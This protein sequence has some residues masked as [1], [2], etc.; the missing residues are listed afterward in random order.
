MSRKLKFTEVM[1]AS[2]ILRQMDIKSYINTIV[3][4][5][6]D[7]LLSKEGLKVEDKQKIIAADVISYIIQSMELAEE[8]IFKLFASYT[9]KSVDEVGNL[10]IDEI[11][12]VFMEIFS[13][14][15]PKALSKMIDVDSLKKKLQSLN[16]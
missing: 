4:D 13:N 3:S 12:T 8:S 2:K 9:G 5:K 14:G 15:V 10:D 6:I 16:Q 1:I 11:I 7:L